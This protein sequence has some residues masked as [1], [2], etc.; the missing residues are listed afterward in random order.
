MCHTHMTQCCRRELLQSVA[1][2]MLLDI[3][4]PQLTNMFLLGLV[5][6]NSSGVIG[7]WNT[8]TQTWK[9]QHVQPI[10]SYDVAGTMI[11]EIILVT[12]GA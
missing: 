8:M 3:F 11:E 10:T 4:T 1:H 6:L 5:A 9:L 2:L 12:R 7:V